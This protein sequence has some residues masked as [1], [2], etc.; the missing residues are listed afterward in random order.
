MI[1]HSTIVG[2][3]CLNGDPYLHNFKFFYEASKLTLTSTIFPYRRI[4]NFTTNA[5]QP[6]TSKDV[7]IDI[8]A[9]ALW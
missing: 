4:H 9:A 5:Y 7:N 2:K 3:S 6:S 1:N 8:T